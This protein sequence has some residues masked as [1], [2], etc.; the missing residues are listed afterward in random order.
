MES[1]DVLHP[2]STQEIGAATT[3]GESAA[4]EGAQ[5][6]PLPASVSVKALP[7][8]LVCGRAGAT[9]S[10]LWLVAFQGQVGRIVSVVTLQLVQLLT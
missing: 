7:L 4:V 9:G 1:A 8:L 6:H 10:S 2:R 3:G 5:A